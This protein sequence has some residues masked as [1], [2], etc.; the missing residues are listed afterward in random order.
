MINNNLLYIFFILFWIYVI[1]NI[2]NSTHNKEK[3]LTFPI[4]SFK[5]QQDEIRETSYGKRTNIKEE[6]FPI[7]FLLILKLSLA[8]GLKIEKSKLKP[9]QKIV[10]YQSLIKKYGIKGK[11]IDRLSFNYNR[12]KETC[13]PTSNY[14]NPYIFDQVKYYNCLHK[15]E[16]T[17]EQKLSLKK[18][19]NLEFIYEP[20]HH[21][22]D[23]P[24]RDPK[25]AIKEIE[26]E[27]NI[28]VRLN[29]IR[30]NHFERGMRIVPKISEKILDI[31][32]KKEVLEKT[33]PFKQAILERYQID[34]LKPVFMYR[35]KD[36]VKDTVG[37]LYE[38]IIHRYNKY[39]VYNFV[40]DVTLLEDNKTFIIHDIDIIAIK[41]SD[42]VTTS[43]GKYFKNLGKENVC[44]LTGNNP[45]CNPKDIISFDEM[46]KNQENDEKLF[47]DEASKKCIGKYTTN[48]D[49]CISQDP[50]TGNV[51]IWTSV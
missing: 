46:K 41:T 47:F 32:N 17:E 25:E 43:F 44:L 16:F 6:K 28:V 9:N 45:N 51:G 39:F 14:D 48:R 20:M 22:M 12:S 10:Y 5:R 33:K 8:K 11:L 19:D 36:E 27:Q 1:Y 50:Q 21:E 3:F 29:Q 31:I 30:Q 26:K 7:T 49:E 38:G 18:L 23:L 24:I 4:S 15:N 2:C 13:T 35:E 37:V 40:L 34:D 42:E